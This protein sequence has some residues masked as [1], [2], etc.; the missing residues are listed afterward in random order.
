L[1][2]AREV[3]SLRY[4]F[5]A[6]ALPDTPTHKVI[7]GVTNED[8]TP[9]ME[10]IQP[11][12]EKYQLAIPEICTHKT[13]E[14]PPWA[15]QPVKICSF[16]NNTKKNRNESELR[17]EFLKHQE[18]HKSEPIYTDGSKMDQQVGWAAKF[19]TFTISDRLPKLTSIFS[20]EI[21]AIKQAL[22]HII[23]EE[24]RN[25]SFTI[26][27][28]SQSA[29]QSLKPKAKPSPLAEEII[30]SH[31]TAA[32]QNITID[33]CWV[34]GHIDI[35]GN[36]E[37]DVAAKNAALN[38][39]LPTNGKPIL[40][41]DMRKP[42]REAI[43]KAWLNEWLNLDRE[44]AKLREI[45]H[46]TSKWDSS[47]YKNRRM[48]TTISRLRIGHTNLTHSYLMQGQA[49]PPVCDRCNQPITVKRI[50]LE[51]RKFTTI[52]NKYF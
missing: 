1:K 22:E 11:L 26:Y 6:H 48:E 25:K 7:V 39:N 42:I 15:N 8:P 46:S 12:L 4:F 35:K 2:Y 17:S 16:L 34:P 9:N 49:N 19:Q 3:I 10:Y 29:I 13:P 37:A 44:G 52:Q 21:Y 14:T 47:Y 5:K 23:R 18:E 40:H 31:N 51:C 45:K 50:L 41:T 28:D 32:S 20:A 38:N 27:S 24:N 36:E 30:V 33:F 43:N